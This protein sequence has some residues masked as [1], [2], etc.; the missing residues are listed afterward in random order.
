VPDR[1]NAD[2][3]QVPRDRVVNLSPSLLSDCET[4]CRNLN[5]TEDDFKSV[6]RQWLSTRGLLV[7]DIPCDPLRRTP[8]FR[9]AA[10]SEND[11]LE[12]KI[13]DRDPDDDTEER[14]ALAA[15]RM[16]ERSVPIRPRNRLDGIIKDGH[17]QMMEFDPERRFFHLLWIH[18]AGRDG[19]TLFERFRFTLFGVR[20]LC[21][22]QREHMIRAYYFHNSAFWRYR[23]GLDGVFLS[24]G[25]TLQLCVNTVSS[26]LHEFRNSRLFSEHENALCDPDRLESNQHAFIVDPIV[27]RRNENV[28]LASLRAKYAV[29]HLQTLD[30][31]AYSVIAPAIGVAD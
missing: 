15:G 4:R 31:G 18:C 19:G 2:A 11:L 27:D 3:H 22:M 23:N 12:L 6:V 30:M 21:S 29:E 24:E 1:T 7:S 28:V 20:H 8:D 26:R 5:V 14:L 16:V 25:D 10:G 17:S 9:L 13:K